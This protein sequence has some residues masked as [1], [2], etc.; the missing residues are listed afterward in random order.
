MRIPL[1]RGRS[2]DAHD[3]DSS[4]KVMVINQTMAERHWHG[5]NPIGQRVTMKDWGP[6]LTGEIVGVVG[7]VKSNALDAQPGDMIYW[8]E[9]QFPSI[10][11]NVVVRVESGR[12]AGQLASALKAAVHSVDPGLPVASIATMEERLA[13]S[14][15]PRRVQTILLGVFAALALSMAVVGIY[16]VMAYSVSGRGREIGIRVALGA[17][18]RMVRNLV[19]REGL[20]W[21]ALGTGIGLA[22]ALALAGV[23]GNLLYGV[24]PRD[25]MTFGGVTLLLMSVAIAACYLPARRA[26]NLDAMRTLRAE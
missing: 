10:F 22:G 9:R 13:T 4:V 6:A 3:T 26:A 15:K 7:D 5:E 1:L 24:A 12:D 8:P 2:F 20:R 17:D 14:V 21:A 25:P 11:D 16:G 19:L 18:S 23:L